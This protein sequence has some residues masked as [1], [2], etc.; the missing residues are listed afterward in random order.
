PG[1]GAHG[2]AGAGPRPPPAPLR[3]VGPCASRMRIGTRAS[4]LARAQ[5]DLVS[6]ALGGCE[7]VP[8]ITSGDRGLAPADKS[9]WVAELEGA[10]LAGEIDLAVHSAKDLPGELAAGLALLGTP[11][12]AA[13]EDVLCGAAGLEQ[14]AE[15][16]VVGTS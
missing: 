3:R 12:R 7:I 14:L 8:M 9:R 16:A 4:A 10:L 2:G 1:G 15:G 6:R 13:A 11:P 5:A